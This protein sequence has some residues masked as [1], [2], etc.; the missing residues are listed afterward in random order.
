MTTTTAQLVD[1]LG[2]RWVE[3]ERN[4]DVDALD[5]LLDERFIAAGPLDFTLTKQEW[6]ERHRSG[7]VRYE[8]VTWEPATTTNL[9]RRRGRHRNAT[10]ANRR[11]RPSPSP[12]DTSEPP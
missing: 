9:R 8:P 4:A 1:Q 6:I 11:I 10:S 7:D 5:E 2:T 12:S 3:A